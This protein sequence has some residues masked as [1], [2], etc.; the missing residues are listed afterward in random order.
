MNLTCHSTKEGSPEIT[1]AVSLT[2]NYL[3]KAKVV[4]MSLL[5]VLSASGKVNQA[6]KKKQV[7]FAKSKKYK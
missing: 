6:R 4:T 1:H 7:K 5:T 2:F 3:L